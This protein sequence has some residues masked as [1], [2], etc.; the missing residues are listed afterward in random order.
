MTDPGQQ[1]GGERRVDGHPAGVPASSGDLH[2]DAFRRHL[3]AT[4][5]S[6][7]SD[8]IYF[9]DDKSRFL[10]ISH[11]MA[12]LF[13]LQDPEQAVGKTDFDFFTPDHARKAYEDEQAIM[14]TGV[15]LIDREEMETWPDG[16]QTWVSTTK[17]PLEDEQGRV[18]GTFGIS[19]DI[20]K[21]KRA[22][23]ELARYRDHLEERIE[24]RTSELRVANEQLQREVAERQ[25]A[26]K[27]LLEGERMAAIRSM[28]GGAAVAFNNI[29]GVIGAYASSIAANVLPKT[30]V[31]EE[32]TRILEA[33]RRAAGLTERLMTMGHAEPGEET[34]LAP[35]ALADLIAE[36]T[37]FVG[38][39]FRER[40]VTIQSIRPQGM[41]FVFGERVQLVDALLTFLINAAEAMPGG[42]VVRL[43]ASVRTVARPPVGVGAGA[44]A[45]GSYA[46]LRI[47]DTGVGM[48]AEVR[49]RIF[50][51]FFTTK[52]DGASFGLGMCFAQSAIQ[53]MGG[54]IQ[55]NSRPGKGTS[56][57]I[58]LPEA[59]AV[60][61]PAVKDAN[62]NEAPL[63]VLCVDDDPKELVKMTQ[64]LERTGC[65]V[66]ATENAQGAL[67]LFARH[68]GTIGLS[69]IDAVLHGGGTAKVVKRIRQLDPK[70]C[71]LMTSGFSRDY[72]RGVLPLGPWGFLQKPFDAEQLAKAMRDTLERYAASR[73]D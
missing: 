27:A 37:D 63:T 58:Y 21:R 8:H 38:E 24:E 51:P 34:A 43:D 69:I 49:K 59:P 39:M 9:N 16:R 52:T 28:A 5:T 17:M 40:S 7:T 25:R 1:Q 68:R 67:A 64:A 6:H 12:R 23:Q 14:L 10:L 42:G 15:P 30:R 46:V 13:Q 47:R 70:A 65:Q 60:A 4:L 72:I 41:P 71:L 73:P 56:F 11:A 55:V 33:T 3:L 29:L 26:E 31:H 22:E 62:G 66:L 50:E 53:S 45:G 20:T 54:W 36:A 19:R 57:R 18:V 32:A 35:V 44:A 48:T 61:L 2:S